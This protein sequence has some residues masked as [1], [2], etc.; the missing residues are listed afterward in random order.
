MKKQQKTWA[1]V[2][3]E[4]ALKVQNTPEEPRRVSR[5][6]QMANHPAGKRR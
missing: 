6:E 2:A 4:H 3:L 5:A 1:Q